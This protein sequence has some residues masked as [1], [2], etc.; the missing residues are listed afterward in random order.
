[1][2]T[3]SGSAVKAL[4]HLLLGKGQVPVLPTDVAELAAMLPEGCSVCGSIAFSF[5]EVLWPSLIESWQITP[6]EVHYINVQQGFHCTRCRNSLRTIT[7]ARAICRSYGY[8]GILD[9]WLA[10]PEGARC[11]ILEIN[12]AGQLTKHLKTVREHVLVSYPE[13]DIHALQFPGGTFDLVVHS[14]T[15]EHVCDPVRALQECRRVLKPGGHLAFTVPIIVARMTRSRHGLPPS[16]HGTSSDIRAD[17]LVE[18]EFGLDTPYFVLKAGFS[19]LSLYTD[20][21]PSSIA[22]SARK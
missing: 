9:E 17:Y 5:R 1:M 10:S 8:V 14:D 16:Y 3:S 19:D 22:F 15:L 18:T 12:E 2:F 13:A 7:L 21:Y 4:P 11:K 6:D 20:L